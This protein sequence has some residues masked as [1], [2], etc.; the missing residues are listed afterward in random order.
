MPPTTKPDLQCSRILAKATLEHVVSGS[1]TDGSLASGLAGAAIFLV[2]LA[3][4]T[5]DQ[6]MA[7]AAII[8]AQDAVVQA[9]TLDP[10]GLYTGFLGAA[11]TSWYVE[12]ILKEPVC[13]P[14]VMREATEIAHE[15]IRVSAFSRDHDLL[16]GALGVGI[17]AISSPIGGKC[18]V[19]SQVLHALDETAVSD[20]TGIRW[21]T[22][23]L[24]MSSDEMTMYGDSGYFNMGT[25]HGQSG[26][27]LFLSLLCQESATRDKASRLLREAVKWYVGRASVAPELLSEGG[28]CVFPHAIEV[29]GRLHF[30]SRLSWCYGDLAAAVAL[31]SAGHALGDSHLTEVAKLI[32]VRTTRRPLCDTGVC[33]NSLCHG[34]SGVALLYQR[35]HRFMII[36]EIDRAARYW[37]R[38]SRRYVIKGALQQEPGL[39]LGHAGTGLVHLDVINSGAH[40]LR[41][42][43]LLS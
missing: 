22:D 18:D 41:N 20:G 39:L 36:D 23:A 13:L 6:T 43:L 42:I 35:L 38:A 21:K 11:W 14:N 32:A 5:E 15:A 30:P 24:M 9:S 8:L 29:D 27:V 34:A 28:S 12:R 33:D 19:I 16:H 37:L 40:L 25:P 3:D 4:L 7:R 10:A 2:H 1:M 17:F 26:I 31:L